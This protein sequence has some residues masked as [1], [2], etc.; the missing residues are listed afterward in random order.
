MADEENIAGLR[1]LDSLEVKYHADDIRALRFLT[2][3]SLMGA[4]RHFFQ[5]VDLGAGNGI[6]AL[7]M[8][9]RAKAVWARNHRTTVYAIDTWEGSCPITQR[10]VDEN[11]PG[12]AFAMFMR[13]IKMYY[14][15]GII[16]LRGPHEIFAATWPP[17]VP[18]SS[19]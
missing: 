17:Q 3:A 10:V 9:R 16:P 4:K 7:A 2:E 14:L 13:N 18:A 12:H 19:V 1:S 8:I 11:L 15:N 6:P 5:T